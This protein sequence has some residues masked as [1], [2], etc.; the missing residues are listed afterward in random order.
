MDYPW[1]STNSPDSMEYPWIIHRYLRIV[2]GVL[3]DFLFFL[4]LCFPWGTRHVMRPEYPGPLACRI[5][6]EL[7]KD[8]FN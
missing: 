7:I 2:H 4:L 5:A 8:R 1:P 3:M 6:C